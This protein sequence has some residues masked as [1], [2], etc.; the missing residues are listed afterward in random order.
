MAFYIGDVRDLANVKNA[1]HGV[2]YIFHTVALKY[3]LPCEF[4][5]IEPVKTN[6]LGIEKE[7]SKKIL[8]HYSRDLLKQELLSCLLIYT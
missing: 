4:F 8:I 2:D 3:V 5:F 6:I 7:Q 1:M